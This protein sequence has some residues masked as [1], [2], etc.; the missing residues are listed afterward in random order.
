MTFFAYETSTYMV[1]YVVLDLLNKSREEC[2]KKLALLTSVGSSTL[3]CVC[4]LEMW[5]HLRGADQIG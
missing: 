3:L 2:E 4:L 5:Q 1:E